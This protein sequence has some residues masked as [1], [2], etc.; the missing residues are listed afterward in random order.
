MQSWLESLQIFKPAN[1]KLFLLV[2][3]KSIVETYKTLFTKFWWVLLG[4]VAMDYGSGYVYA[5]Y[6]AYLGTY[7]LLMV[8]LAIFILYVL[9]LVAR[10]SVQ[11]KN[12]QYIWN[13]RKHFLFFLLMC[14]L[15]AVLFQN[16][17]FW[18]HLF[19]I[20]VTFG[21]SPLFI[22]TTC[23][24]LDSNGSVRS[25]ILSIWRGIKFCIFNYPFCLLGLLALHCLL[26][27]LSLLF[28]YIFYI[29]SMLLAALM[30]DGGVSLRYGNVIFWPIP[31][32]FFMNFYI[33][34]LHEQF[35]LYFEKKGA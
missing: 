16:Q 24:L 26:Y 1:F 27:V 2:T 34:R 4:F 18:G 32:C 28:A 31:I 19:L 29:L 3:L 15:V 8:L 5:N 20:G 12:W 14:L 35:E 13:Y 7:F 11:Q 10:P 6:P 9:F 23:F 30:I 21:V 25:S 22:V 17:L 33:K